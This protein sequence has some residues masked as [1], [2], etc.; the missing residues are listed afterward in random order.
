MTQS[1]ALSILKSGANVFLTGEP[2]SGK[3]HTIN[4]YVRWLRSHAIE[5]SITASTG[6]AATHIHGVTIHSWSGIGIAEHL[7]A[8]LIENI[9]QK[10]H[11]VKRIQRTNVLIIDEISMLSADVLTMVDAV[12]RE[13]R[14][15]EE[16]FGGMQVV[17]V[18][19]FF[20]LPPIGKRGQPSS[21][22]FESPIW[23]RLNP[24]ICYL[25]EQ[26]R[27]EDQDLLSLL[28]AI[29]EGSSD[30]THVSLILSRE[31]DLEGLDEDTPRLYTHNADVDRENEAKLLA[32][33]GSSKRFLMSAAG[34]PPLVEGL[35]RGCLS[36]ETLVLKEGAVVMAT[37]NN[38]IAGYA[39]GTTG[40]VVEFEHGSGYPVIETK[41]GRMITMAPMDWAVEEGGKVRAKVTQVPLRLAWAITVHKSQGMSMDRAAMD[42]SRAFEYGQGYVAL[43]RVRSLEGLSLLGWHENALAIHPNVAAKDQQF[44]TLSEQAALAF[45]TLAES[46]ELETMHNNFIKASGGSLEVREGIATLEKKTTY[47]A[48]YDLIK[49]GKTLMD[50]KALRGLT[51]GTLAD[52]LEKLKEAG[53]ITIDEIRE[54]MP[55]KILEAL[56]AI[57][58]AFEK[59]GLDKLAP[60]H[61]KLK[62]KYTYD[63]LKLARLICGERG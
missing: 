60:V 56:P 28:G 63:D 55:K 39:N 7:T 16:P 62:G 18:G 4:E 1:E 35:K 27:Q 50:I 41:D 42:L 43:S 13:V 12:C 61:T 33:K 45:G 52:H 8:Q 29:R 54:L 48:T 19:D 14:H 57:S 53:R 11:V 9:S 2:G 23:P 36:P 25:S 15:R 30:H 17:L 24:I 38:P 46:G 49:E 32:L 34:A 47:D 3:T 58:E 20:Q 51:I 59:V 37:K 31:T 44:R 22:A 40:V 10:E 6:I 21:F 5:P 26:H